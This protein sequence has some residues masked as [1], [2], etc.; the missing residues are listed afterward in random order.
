MKSRFKNINK[1]LNTLINNLPFTII[2]IIIYFLLLGGILSCQ[3]ILNSSF[4]KTFSVVC[5]ILIFNNYLI[6][7]LKTDKEIK[8]ISLFISVVLSLTIGIMS[9]FGNEIFLSKLMHII[10]GYVLTLL[11]ISIYLNYKNSNNEFG[12]YLLKT[13]S[14]FIKI[15]INYFALA[16]GVLFITL[17]FNYLILN[18]VDFLSILSL[19]TIVF[20][21]YYIPSIL[22]RLYKPE[23]ETENFFK[24]LISYIL[25][26]VVTIMF[27]I[28]YL[29]ML[30][31]LIT[32]N[33]PENQVFELI[34]IFFL[35]AMP[36]WTMSKHLK[37]NKTEKKLTFYFPY[38]FVPLIFIQIYCLSIRVVNYG[39]T[40]TRYLGIAFIILEIIYY[41]IYF[42]ESKKCGQILLFM[43]GFAFVTYS[44]P[45]VNMYDLS[46]QNQ[47]NRLKAYSEIEN[48]SNE[49]LQSLS[50]SYYYL[51][52]NK[53]G[54]LYLNNINISKSYIDN[55]SSKYYTGQN[56]YYNTDNLELNFNIKDYNNAKIIKGNIEN[57][58]IDIK[59]D[60]KTILSFSNTDKFNEYINNRENLQ[61]YLKQNYEI[62]INDNNKII[63]TQINFTY[64]SLSKETSNYTFEGILLTK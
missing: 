53:E 60:N 12:N 40:T 42:T 9:N 1:I 52:F 38:L 27:I 44:I 51:Y 48:P 32:F 23:K 28:I 63:I 31:L 8:K 5:L 64:N 61:S 3:N 57:D 39:L 47:F 4:F 34:T 49:E 54:K 24:V 26:P 10:T 15:T 19:Q 25:I 55:I 36:V 16:F 11:F 30:K 45:Y 59:Q 20:G 37:L 56:D 21:C 50:S 18:Q 13:F 41:I 22:Y 14:S 7:S 62:E 58:N 33:L 29:Y 2:P 17:A 6:E 35:I 46:N 43:A